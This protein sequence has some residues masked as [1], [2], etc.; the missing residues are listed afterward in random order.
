MDLQ[1]KKYCEPNVK[2]EASIVD[3][4]QNSNP[5]VWKAKLNDELIY[6]SDDGTRRQKFYF[7]SL[8]YDIL[9]ERVTDA[10]I[11]EEKEVQ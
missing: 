7:E 8:T 2:T 4:F 3:L 1:K 9:M 11:V 10:E 6:I 5:T